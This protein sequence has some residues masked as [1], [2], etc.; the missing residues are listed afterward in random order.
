[1]ACACFVRSGGQLD[2]TLNGPTAAAAATRGSIGVAPGATTGKGG[3][4]VAGNDGT[5]APDGEGAGASFHHERSERTAGSPPGCACVSH[6][7]RATRKS[8]PALWLITDETSAP[9]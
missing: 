1:M 4:M 6:V 9:G 2:G 3:V 7:A 8:F 5:G